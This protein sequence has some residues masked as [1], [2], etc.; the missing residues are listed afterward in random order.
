[1]NTLQ[2]LAPTTREV[3]PIT[4][5]QSAVAFAATSKA[6]DTAKTTGESLVSLLDP[7]AGQNLDRSA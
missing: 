5:L 2:S 7:N 3:Q 1:M 4:D 6:L